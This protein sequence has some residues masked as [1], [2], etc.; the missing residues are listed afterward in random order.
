[1]QPSPLTEAPALPELYVTGF[2]YLTL[3]DGL[4]RYGICCERD[5]LAREA[6]PDPR[7]AP[8]QRLIVDRR[9]ITI[10]NARR[11]LAELRKAL[12]EAG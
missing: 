10:E 12:E 4:L 1:M 3:E 9:V 5:V 11:M 6:S 2:A 7:F 8:R